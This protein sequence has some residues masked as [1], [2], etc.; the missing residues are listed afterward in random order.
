MPKP[1]DHAFNEGHTNIKTPISHAS[2]SRNITPKK[3]TDQIHQEDPISNI[4]TY[5]PNFPQPQLRKPR[6][7]D[8]SLE[9]WLRIKLGQ[10]NVNKSIRNEVLNEWVINSFDVEI[11]YGKTHDSRRFDEYKEVFDKEIKQLANEYDLRI[12]KKGGIEKTDYKPPFV[13]IE[14]FE[15]KRYSF[16]RGKSFV[17]ITKQLDEALP[18]GRANGSRFM[19]I[20]RKEMNMDGTTKGETFSQ[21][22][23]GIQGLPDSFSCGDTSL[24]RIRG[25]RDGLLPLSFKEQSNA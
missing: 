23:N 20:I 16:K 3:N 24:F 21:Q 9:E 5:F 7:R 1:W 4:K 15:V 17:C 2:T 10:T 11:D 13:K 14:T 19:G 18:L 12:G 25:S 8:Y 22:G 6:P